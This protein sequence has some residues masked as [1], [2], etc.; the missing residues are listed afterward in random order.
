[1]SFGKRPELTAPPEF[2]RNIEL[3]FKMEIYCLLFSGHSS[4][5][6]II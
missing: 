4:Q 5:L 2:V 3:K 6:D 1:M